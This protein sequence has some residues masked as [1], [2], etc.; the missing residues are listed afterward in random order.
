MNPMSKVIERERLYQP[1]GDNLVLRQATPADREKLI[2]FNRQMHDAVSGAE[3]AYLVDGNHKGFQIED[4]L[5][6]VDQD[7]RIISTLCLAVVE[8]R[9]GQTVIRMGQP[10]FVGTLTEYRGRGL[11]RKQFEVLHQWMTERGLGLALIGGIEYYYR[12]FG[13]EY[14]VSI[15]RAGLLTPELHAAKI[16]VPPGI[17][18]RPITQADIPTLIELEAERDSRYDISTV[19]AENSWRWAV[20][21]HRLEKVEVE[22]WAVWQAGKLI[23]AA[24]MGGKPDTFWA[25]NFLGNEVAAAAIIAKIL[26]MPGIAKLR[27][28]APPESPVH[29]WVASL[30]PIPM[31][32]YAFYIRVHNPVLALQELSGELERRIAA[33]SFAG[34]SREL[35]LGC[36]RFGLRLVFENGKLSEVSEVAGRQDPKIGVPPD[37]L[38]KLFL[39]FRSVEQLRDMYPDFYANE[40]ADWELLKVLFPALSN[41][42]RFFI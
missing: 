41:V 40:R 20:E 27:V 29:K 32:P 9:I 26:A 37:L 11:V 15:W 18:V 10:E 1:L 39:G 25:N 19:I 16:S 36:Y 5:V 12:L 14:G 33:S 30:D 7:E 17:E 23:G 34:L 22:N 35:E 28:G 13:Y 8:W 31:L 42:T 2:E 24:R 21:N 38:P 3:V 6:V 4:F